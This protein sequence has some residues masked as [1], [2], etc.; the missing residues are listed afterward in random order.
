MTAQPSRA[1]EALVALGVGRLRV[2]ADRVG[3]P[4]TG[5]ND[6]QTLA[7]NVIAAVPDVNELQHQSLS[8][9]DVEAIGVALG[10]GTRAAWRPRVSAEEF[11]RLPFYNKPS[12]DADVWAALAAGWSGGGTGRH[13]R[14]DGPIDL[15][16]TFVHLGLGA[17][18]V[19][20]EPFTGMDW[21]ERYG[22]RNASDG[23]EGRLVTLHSFDKPWDSWEMHPKGHELVI[24]VAGR[25][26][27][28]QEQSDGSVRATTLETGQA[29]INAPG[30]WHTADVDAPAT[31][32]FITAGMGTQHRAR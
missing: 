16:R 17:T 10:L 23:L 18:C 3:A 7:A 11:E 30:V 31:A 28:H 25:M 26:V 19:P 32:V 20:Q 12:Y 4:T 1:L 24:C 27:L 14:M 9:V 8:D 2:L 15:A 13:P 6:A 5:A 21:Y 29:A 22:T